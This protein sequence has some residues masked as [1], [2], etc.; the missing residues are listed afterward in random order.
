MA[1]PSASTVS[2]GAGVLAFGVATFV[3][4]VV[5]AMLVD[6][7]SVCQRFFLLIWSTYP[8][9]SVVLLPDR[10]CSN[11]VL[12]VTNLKQ[13]HI[14]SKGRLAPRALCGS[15]AKRESTAIPLKGVTENWIRGR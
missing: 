5:L 11:A 3:V 1:F 4:L 15:D 7:P 6:F 12:E 2:T 14:D 10:Y 13:A 9:T 8:Y